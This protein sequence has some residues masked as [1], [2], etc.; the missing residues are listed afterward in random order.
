MYTEPVKGWSIEM[1]TTKPVVTRTDKTPVIET[2]ANQACKAEYLSRP[3]SETGVLGEARN[4]EMRH[5][6]SGFACRRGG[7]R[8]IE[9]KKIAPD[10]QA[11]HVDRLELA[12]RSGRHSLSVTQDRHN[13]GDGFDL[14]EPMRNVENRHPL[15]LE[16][17]NELQEL[18]RL[19]GRQ[20]SGRLVENG[21][22][23][24]D[25]KGPSDLC[26]LALRDGEP[27]DGF[28]NWSGDPEDTHRLERPAVHFLVVQ[29]QPPPDFAAQKHVL[30]YREIW[31]QHDLLMN[32]DD[33]APFRVDRPLQLD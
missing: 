17:A 24:R 14:F 22:P 7:T 10:H 9:G 13:V 12:C 3:D 6:E 16:L 31:R 25:R 18:G 33:P 23:V 19:N 29:G 20:R 1:M 15:R 26:Q 4:A 27:H 30:G 28:R 21:D 2:R 32:Q 8:R 11:R 5:F